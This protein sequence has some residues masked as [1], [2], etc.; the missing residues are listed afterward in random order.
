[1]KTWIGLRTWLILFWGQLEKNNENRV[2][3]EDI[4]GM[5]HKCPCYLPLLAIHVLYYLSDPKFLFFFLFI[6]GLQSSWPKFNVRKW[7]NIRSNDDKFH[8]DASYYS[9]PGKIQFSGNLSFNRFFY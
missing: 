2:E 5:K 7:L 8:S 6:F 4:Q 9:L 1:M 3:E